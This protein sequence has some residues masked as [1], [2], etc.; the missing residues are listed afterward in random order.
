MKTKS[1]RRKLPITSTLKSSNALS[2]S[3]SANPLTSARLIRHFHVLLKRRAQLEKR[4]ASKDNAKELREIEEEIK[5]M[6]GLEAYQRMSSIGQSGD[7]G[8]GSEKVLISWLKELKV[9][10][11]AMKA[12]RRTRYV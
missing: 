1:R 2:S 7:R 10:D 4:K 12:K 9:Q 8:G 6:G 11:A 3:S 5:S